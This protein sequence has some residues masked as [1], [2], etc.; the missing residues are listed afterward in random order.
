MT[1]NQ[2][3]LDENQQNQDRK[4]HKQREIQ[5][6]QKRLSDALRDNLKKRKVQQKERAI[7]SQE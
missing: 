3:T 1:I 5:L 4:K 2:D 7:L 6:K